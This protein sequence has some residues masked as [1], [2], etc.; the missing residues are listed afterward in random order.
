MGSATVVATA[1]A[2]ILLMVTAYFL[3]AVV[4]ATAEVVSYAQQEKLNQQELRVKTSISIENTSAVSLPPVI[5][6]EI[7]NQG[8]ASISDFKYWDVYT[9]NSSSDPPVYYPM[10]SGYSQWNKVSIIPDLINPGLL[11]PDEIMN[12][13]ISYPGDKPRWIKIITPNGVSASAY[14]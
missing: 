12:I 8:T 14:V 1:F 5:Y 7:K 10:G 3:V 11:D 4:L 6:A 9:G 13:S 2:L